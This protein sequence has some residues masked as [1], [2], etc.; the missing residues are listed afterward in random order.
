MGFGSIL[1]FLHVSTGC[2]GC[3]ER[4]DL[5]RPRPEDLYGR[6]PSPVLREGRLWRRQRGRQGEESEQKQGEE[7][8]PE[9]EQREE[10]EQKQVQVQE[11]GQEEQE[12]E[13]GP[14]EEQDSV[15]EQRSL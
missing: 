4:S 9:Q 2:P 1:T 7:E 14:K 10:E 11:Q 6:R 12:Q 13:Q 8:E 15:Q 5:R 3:P